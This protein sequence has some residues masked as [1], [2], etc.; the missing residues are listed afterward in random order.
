[1]L[2][3]SVALPWTVFQAHTGRSRTL[4]LAASVA[5]IIA[6][7]LPYGL[8]AST[9]APPIDQLLVQP[10]LRQP[11]HWSAPALDAVHKMTTEPARTVGV[12]WTLVPGVH[13]LYGLEG[14]GG[15]D[16]LQIPLYEELVG[17]GGMV[18]L[19]SWFTTVTPAGIVQAGPLL[20]MLNVRALLSRPDL[21]PPGTAEVSLDGADRLRVLRRES[22]WPRAFFVDGIIQYSSATDLVRQVAE[23][24]LPFA[25]IQSNDQ[26]A[27]EATRR[28]T[29]P[30]G[31]VT[32]AQQYTLTVNTTSYLVRTTGPGVAVLGETFLPDDFHATL[33]GLPVPYFRVN[34]AFKGVTIPAAGDWV[35]KFEYVPPRWRASWT[36]AGAGAVLLMGLGL[37][38]IVRARQSR[39]DPS[40]IGRRDTVRPSET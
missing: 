20:D 21:V 30:S 38:G 16:A 12:E 35:V 14:V 8:H 36:L 33:N 26:R 11:L 23:R 9:G 3:L 17:A 39:L 24:R 27:L 13:A 1:M 18:R 22:A 40:S 32:A 31:T 10:R 2:A 34:H 7:L 28:F 19:G 25:A 37:A 5:A 29:R 6:L 4:S 15:A